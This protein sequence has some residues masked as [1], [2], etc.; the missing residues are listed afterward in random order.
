MISRLNSISSPSTSQFVAISFRIL[1]HFYRNQ[2]WV[3]RIPE[4]ITDHA[5]RGLPFSTTRL[6]W[7]AAKLPGAQRKERHCEYPCFG[8][9]SLLD[10]EQPTSEVKREKAQD[11]RSPKSCNDKRKSFFNIELSNQRESSVPIETGGDKA[12]GSMAGDCSRERDCLA[13]KTA[14]SRDIRIGW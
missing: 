13:C 12:E 8:C 5:L 1:C 2:K 3:G 14:P 6:L 10:N 4:R 11:G 7:L 9:W